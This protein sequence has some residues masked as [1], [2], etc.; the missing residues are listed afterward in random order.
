MRTVNPVLRHPSQTEAIKP[1]YA[2]GPEA[3]LGNKCKPAITEE[4][5]KK[6]AQILGCAR[7]LAL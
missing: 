7:F 3:E 1:S 5:L 4:P 6:N 2:S